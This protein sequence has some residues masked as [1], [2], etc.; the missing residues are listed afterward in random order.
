VTNIKRAESDEDIIQ[1]RALWTEYWETLGLP[2]E[3]QGFGEQLQRLPGEFAAPSG[4]LLLASGAA[5]TVAVRP[6]DDNACEAK[7]LYVPSRFRG[8]GFGR[9]LLREA[10]AG[11]RQI[12]YQVMYGDTLPTMQVAA[13]LYAELG[14]KPVGP[15]SENPTPG[16][17]YL[18]L[19]LT[20]GAA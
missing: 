16:A 17:I 20:N 11:A 4:L 6:F 5:G 10:I 8:Q 12:G 1:V 7:R 14:F 13:G 15:Y 9:Q 19:D 18:K 2:L 3:F